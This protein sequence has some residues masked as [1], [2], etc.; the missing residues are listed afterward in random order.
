MFARAGF[1]ESLGRATPRCLKGE[2][3]ITSTAPHSMSAYGPVVFNAP[4]PLTIKEKALTV[5]ANSIQENIELLRRELAVANESVNF[6]DTC[7][8]EDIAWVHTHCELANTHA[9]MNTRTVVRC[10]KMAVE[11]LQL[12]IAG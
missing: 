2:M 12:T 11:K 10:R 4:Q 7:V 1:D 5:D 3:D 8:D 6:L 9:P